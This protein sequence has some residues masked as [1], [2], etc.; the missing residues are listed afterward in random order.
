MGS[1]QWIITDI[2]FWSW[3]LSSLTSLGHDR[4][5]Q[6]AWSELTYLKKQRFRTLHIVGSRDLGSD[7][8]P[9]SGTT[10]VVS[11]SLWLKTLLFAFSLFSGLT[12]N[13]RY[14]SLCV[15]VKDVVT[16][17][18]DQ[19]PANGDV[20]S[21]YFK[22]FPGYFPPQGLCTHW[23]LCLGNSVSPAFYMVDSLST[24][25]SQLRV[26]FCF[27]KGLSWLSQVE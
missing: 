23:P 5:E 25:R 20:V 24:F 11:F 9:I 18:S 27:L 17:T 2:L 13:T 16:Q 6:V 21:F 12:L 14:C 8:L 7:Y 10:L 1:N 3:S 4:T 15:S 19:W 26:L 22:C